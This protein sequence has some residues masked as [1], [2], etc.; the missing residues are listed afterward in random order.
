MHPIQIEL[1]CNAEMECGLEN[2]E[3]GQIRLLVELG[4]H[5][6]MECRLESTE[7]VFEEF[8]DKAF[9]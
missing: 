1:S 5:T 8:V 6:K 4:S 3:S 9:Y 7:L 2:A